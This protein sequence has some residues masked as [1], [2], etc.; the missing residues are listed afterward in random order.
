MLR[1]RLEAAGFRAQQAGCPRRFRQ[2]LGAAGQI[3]PAPVLA[4]NRG[5][6]LF[7]I[8]YEKVSDPSHKLAPPFGVGTEARSLADAGAAMTALLSRQFAG[9]I[10]LET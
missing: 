5:R 2:G 9:K 4:M 6:P 3:D 7:S 1:A 10:V 8:T